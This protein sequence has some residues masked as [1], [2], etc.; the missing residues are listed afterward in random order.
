VE[1]LRLLVLASQ[2]AGTVEA[3]EA[4]IA[5]RGTSRPWT[6]WLPPRLL[7]QRMMVRARRR[8]HHRVNGSAAPHPQ[9]VMGAPTG[10]CC[11]P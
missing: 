6:G 3:S 1:E 9:T 11:L 2:Q 5:S 8:A 7:G 4:R 10:V